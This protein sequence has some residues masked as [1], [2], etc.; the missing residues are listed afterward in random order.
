MTEQLPI[1]SI[2]MRIRGAQMAVSGPVVAVRLD[3]GR[4]LPERQKELL[5]ALEGYTKVADATIAN[6]ELGM[7]RTTWR[8]GHDGWFGLFIKN[9]APRKSDAQIQ[10]GELP[11]LKFTVP[12]KRDKRAQK[13]MQ[14]AQTM[15]S[16]L[17][18][19][20]KTFVLSSVQAQNLGKLDLKLTALP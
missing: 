6:V 14:L 20:Y 4:T 1:T 5:Q 10:T 3:S 18:Q 12:N 8:M 7:Q 2:E 16:W 9:D 13:L 11:E 19:G 17:G 15:D